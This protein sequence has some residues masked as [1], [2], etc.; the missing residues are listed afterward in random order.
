MGREGIQDPVSPP[1]LQLMNG[2]DKLQGGG[3]VAR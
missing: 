1:L 3:R 2:E